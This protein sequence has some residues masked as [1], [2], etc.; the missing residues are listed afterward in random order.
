[1]ETNSWHIC[2]KVR[3]GYSRENSKM[4]CGFCKAKPTQ[5][6]YLR[7]YLKDGDPRGN[8]FIP[9]DCPCVDDNFTVDEKKNMI[10][11]LLRDEIEELGLSSDEIFEFVE[12]MREYIDVDEVKHILQGDYEWLLE[13]SPERLLSLENMLSNLNI[14]GAD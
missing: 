2:D 8:G 4:P 10:T 14:K 9:W 1:M 12:H 11:A 7:F 13:N 5:A 6:R 3:S